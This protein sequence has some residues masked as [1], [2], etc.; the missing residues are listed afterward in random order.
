MN[1]LLVLSC[2]L[3]QLSFDICQGPPGHRGQKGNPGFVGP[4]VNVCMRVCDVIYKAE[5][6]TTRCVHQGPVC[7]SC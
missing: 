3:I 4:K 6:P 2:N 1:F 7:V 5:P